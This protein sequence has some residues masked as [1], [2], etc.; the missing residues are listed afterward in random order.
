LGGSG[1]NGTLKSS[2]FWDFKVETHPASSRAVYSQEVAR[3]GIA[4]LG[5]REATAGECD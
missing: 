2:S 5:A 1:E 3:T 4:L